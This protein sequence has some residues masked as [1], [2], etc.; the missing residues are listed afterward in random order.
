VLT[1]SFP[2]VSTS[3]TTLDMRWGTKAVRIPIVVQPTY[4]MTFAEADVAPYVGTYD[5]AWTD[6]D[7]KNP[8]SQFT[9]VW[10]GG[11]LVGQWTPAQFGTTETWLLGEGPDRFVRSFVPNGELWSTIESSVLVFARSDGRVTG[12]ELRSGDEVSARGLRRDRVAIRD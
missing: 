10:R 9:I 2:E 11:R 8:R 3:G 6:P 12:F 7:N 5:F 1:W 4:A